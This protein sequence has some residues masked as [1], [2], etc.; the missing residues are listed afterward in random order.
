MHD[1]RLL[2]PLVIIGGGFAF[3]A[4]ILYGTWLLGRYRGREERDA[5]DLPN[6]E[7]RLDRLEYTVDHMMN[8]FERLETA[9]SLQPRIPARSTP[10]EARLRA[11]NI[12]P[13]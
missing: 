12:T 4:A 3:G 9:Q 5:R 10:P 8:A 2:L 13:Q 1:L 7:A 11:Q 6:M